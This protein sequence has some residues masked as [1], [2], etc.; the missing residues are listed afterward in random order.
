[1]LRTDPAWFLA[2]WSKLSDLGESAPEEFKNVYKETTRISGRK[3]RFWTHN[4]MEE[5]RGHLDILEEYF[6][7]SMTE[8][9]HTREAIGQ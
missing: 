2:Q 6:L 5:M 9:L 1:M 3:L 7:L 4:S 8:K